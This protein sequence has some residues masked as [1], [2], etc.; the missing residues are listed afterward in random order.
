MK[1][2]F[3][4]EVSIGDTVVISQPK[5]YSKSLRVGVVEKMTSTHVYIKGNRN[6]KGS[7]VL[8]KSIKEDENNGKE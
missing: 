5:S 3:G 2:I 8:V 6:A 7:C 1:D 4:K